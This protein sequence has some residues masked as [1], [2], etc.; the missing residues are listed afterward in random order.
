MTV[1]LSSII[2]VLEVIYLIELIS[3]KKRGAIN[4]KKLTILDFMIALGYICQIF[5]A[6]NDWRG[7]S[8]F[9]SIVWCL[10]F[11]ADYIGLKENK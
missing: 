5:L 7:F 2:L 9:C 8:I 4:Y 11:L 10:F 3:G 1:L 6:Y